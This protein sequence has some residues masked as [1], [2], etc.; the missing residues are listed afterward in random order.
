M[1]ECRS[2]EPGLK[3]VESTLWATVRSHAKVSAAAE[4]QRCAQCRCEFC[5]ADKP[6]TS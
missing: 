4:V 5:A 6:V 2:Q 1:A 3:S